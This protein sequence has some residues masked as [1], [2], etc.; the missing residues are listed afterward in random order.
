MAKQT[1]QMNRE[2]K[3]LDA[4]ET[5]PFFLYVRELR[6]RTVNEESLMPLLREPTPGPTHVHSAI[7]NPKTTNNY[8]PAPVGYSTPASIS[9]ISPQSSSYLDTN[10]GD[11]IDDIIKQVTHTIN[12][13][14]LTS[15]AGN[16][17]TN[18]LQ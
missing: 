3:Q 7:Q 8:L 12:Q 18:S 15:N 4:R 2:L 13:N 17:S 14:L 6:G 11:M 10:H 9:S 5:D 1:N 16:N